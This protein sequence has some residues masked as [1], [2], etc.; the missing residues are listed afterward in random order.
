[1]DEDYERR[2]IEHFDLDKTI[3]G[4]GDVS[5]WSVGWRSWEEKGHY[6]YYVVSRLGRL[7]VYFALNS[8]NLYKQQISQPYG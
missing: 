5:S 1:M 3:H 2:H 7:F 4:I 6:L 8:S